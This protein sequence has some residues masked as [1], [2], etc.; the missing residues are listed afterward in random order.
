MGYVSVAQIDENN[1]LSNIYYRKAIDVN[2]EVES[3]IGKLPFYAI[4]LD[5]I[6]KAA[7]LIK[8]NRENH[9]ANIV[10]V[11]FNNDINEKVEEEAT[12]KLT[13]LITDSYDVEEIEVSPVKVL[14]M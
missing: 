2:K 7:S 9:T 10:M 1:L 14:S 5:G 4:Y 3:S 11:N 12:K 13:D 8:L 6:Y